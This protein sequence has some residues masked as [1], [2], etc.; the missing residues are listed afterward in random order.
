VSLELVVLAPR[1]LAQRDDALAACRPLASL[2][3]HAGRPATF[4]DIYAALFATLGLSHDTPIGPLALLGSGR[5]PGDDFVLCAQPAHLDAGPGHAL[6]VAAVCDL[7]SAEADEL[8]RMLDRHFADDD[9]RFDAVREGEWFARRSSAT[10]VAMTTPEAARG[11]PLAQS[12]PRGPD[13]ARWTRWQDEIG[14]LLHDHRVNR[15]REASG[16]ALVNAIWLFG[17]GKMRDVRGVPP[18]S[19]SSLAPT[20]V[21]D[22][23]RGL[24]RVARG[25]RAESREAPLDEALAHVRAMGNA[26][27]ADSA[28]T[29]SMT[30]NGQETRALD[31]A[32][33]RLE[34]RRI[35]ALHLVAGGRGGAIAWTAHAPNAWRRFT[36]RMMPRRFTPPPPRDASPRS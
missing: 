7:A 28:F 4:R 21:G 22:L 33:T 23:A 29:V 20:F 26:A 32:L 24:A 13:A 25:E 3:H 12:L 18:L 2:V 8:V 1:L 34:R 17:G 14:M 35:D 27:S 5:D 15:E 30:A 6:D 16:K 36:A 19:L 10:D 11:Q 31:E 9:L